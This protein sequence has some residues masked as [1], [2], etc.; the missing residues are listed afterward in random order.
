MFRDVP[1]NKELWTLQ[2]D[3][4]TTIFIC[5][6]RRDSRPAWRSKSRPVARWDA[7]M[8][9][10]P[11]GPLV[12]SAARTFGAL[13]PGDLTGL[14]VDAVSGGLVLLRPGCG[15]P[16]AGGLFQAVAIAVQRQDVDVMGEPVEQRPGQAL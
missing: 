3:I 5:Q 2:A 12:I 6:R 7:D 15:A 16:A 4:P 1:S 13:R 14:G 8:T 11:I 9:R 10:G